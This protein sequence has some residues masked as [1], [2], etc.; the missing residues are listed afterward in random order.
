MKCKLCNSE[1]IIEKYI[2]DKFSK[3]FLIYECKNCNFMFQNTDVENAYKFYTEEY[4]KQTQD[5]SYIDERE[6][7][8]FARYVWKKRFKILKKLEK[9]TGKDKNFLDV[10]CSFGGLMKVS[11]E[12]GYKAYG[13]EVSEYSGKYSK[14]RFGKDR[15]FIGSIENVKLPEEKFSIVTMIEVIEHIVDPLKAIFNI[16]NSMKKGGV[17]LIQTANMSGLQAKL[18]GKKYHYF[19]PGHISYFN[20]KN[21]KNLLKEIGFNKIKVYGG[22]EFG[23]LPKLLKSRGDFKSLP[24]Y[25]KW[26]RISLYHLIS[27]IKI[28]GLFFTSSMVVIARK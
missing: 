23:L 12:N 19:L 20:H 10:G 15:V 2:I 17:L 5:Y 26:I 1:D 3:D 8:H 27:K 24:D 14:E 28:C 4:Y 22:V 11:E 6:K 9:T 18:F 16:Y 13:V 21:L 25:L 7:E